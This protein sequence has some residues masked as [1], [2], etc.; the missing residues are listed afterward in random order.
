MEA[1]RRRRRRIV[2]EW[3]GVILA[4]ALC[5]GVTLKGSRGHLTHHLP[6]GVDARLAL[7]LLQWDLDA[8]TQAKSWHDLWQLPCLVPEPNMLATTDPLLGGAVLYA[9]LYWLT[10]KPV[11]AFNLW[12][13]LLTG[14]NFLSAYVVARRLLRG[15]IPAL[16]CAVLFAF[17]YVRMVHNDHWHLWPHFPTPLV[18]LA[19]VRLAEGGGW[20]WALAAGLGLASQ[21]YLS[22]YLGYMA[23]LMV[24]ILL[25][26]LLFHTPTRFIE[27]RF[28]MRLALAG[29]V[30]AIGLAPLIPPYHWAAK[31]WG[32][33]N[34]E[35]T[36]DQMPAWR[37]YFTGWE[38]ERT[39]YVG[40]VA[41]LLF[42]VG[43]I[44]L[45]R[46]A[47]RRPARTRFWCISSVVLVAV[48]ACI[49]VNHFGMYRLLYRFVPGF[50]A[51][52]S[53]ARLTLL[54]IWPLALVGGWTLAWYGRRP[55]HHAPIRSVLLGLGL[56]SLVFVENY[57]NW[58]WV[59]VR[60][61]D[62]E[63]YATVMRH[64]PEGAFVD[65]PLNGLGEPPSNVVKGQRLQGAM[66]A[67]W[68]PTLN[69]CSGRDPEW[70]R[71][72]LERQPQV[73]SREQA[74]SLMGEWRLRGIRYVLLHKTEMPAKHVRSWVQARTTNGQPWGQIIY[75]DAGHLILD[76]ESSAVEA[77]L[78]AAWAACSV[79]K[80]V[81][82]GNK[83]VIQVDAAA[84]G[85]VAFR[86]CLPL[87]P[88]NYRASFD[89]QAGGSGHCE[90]D[91]LQPETRPLP[92][93]LAIAS[94]PQER[95]RQLLEVEF[96]AP[97]EP[98]PEPLLEFRL[99]KT[100]PAALRVFGVTI[101]PV[102]G[103]PDPERIQD[104]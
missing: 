56:V 23:A 74:A 10:G 7:C 80:R 94:L 104:P 86:P 101:T 5:V 96:T 78:P 37:H 103:R 52:R 30:A 17:A 82:R 84:R 70:Y 76:M 40:Y 62:E 32:G 75:E 50:N 4:L 99:V 67:G 24:A 26:T 51:L 47:L 95:C 79:G 14:L 28:L 92:L 49:T 89:V 65:F 102:P 97:N 16:F 11:L 58:P 41:I 1:R 73:S 21:F 15:M 100:G 83:S 20:R 43:A 46:Q 48:L 90:V 81:R 60:L 63:F 55:A 87:R 42:G 3:A 25:L 45:V 2:G 71:G 19:A 88:G 9:P 38:G 66:A 6:G 33:W 77:R 85:L 98:G 12:V 91:Q 93:V 29:S 54:T 68:R 34:W 27:W 18:F 39:T 44:G 69:L 36:A 22:M 72:L 53:S 57:E 64:L 35:L 31:R 61:P 13:M 8:W 59:D